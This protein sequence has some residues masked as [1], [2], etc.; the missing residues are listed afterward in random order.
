M[1][2]RLAILIGNGRF[3]A[4]PSL[5]ELF[6][7]RHDVASLGRLLS[8]P[9]IGNYIVF[10]LIDRDSEQLLAEL[11]PLFSMGHAG[12]NV[13]LYYAGIV[14]SEPGR[15]LYLATTDTEMA[16]VNETALPVSSL[17]GLL[18]SC[19]AVETTVVFDCCYA[20]P[21]GSVDEAAI[22]H[23]LRRVRTDVSPDL[24][25]IASP[26]KTRSAVEREVPTDTGIEGTMTRCIVEGLS[27]G[28]ADRDGDNTTK[29]SELNE[30]LG[31]RMGGDRPLWAGPLEG[32]DPE[33]VANPN[34]IEGVDGEEYQWMVE[35]R[36]GVRRLVRG[37][38][39]VAAVI[40][41]FSAG[42]FL[43]RDSE[44]RRAV[45]VDEYYV[46]SGMPEVYGLVDSLDGIRATIDRT[47]WV[48]HPEPLDGRGPRYPSAYSFRLDP[49]NTTRLGTVNLRLRQWAQFEF[50]EG[51]Y[52]VGVAC[53]AG[54]NIAEVVVQLVDGQQYV[55]DVR[56]EQVGEGFFGFVS[57]VPINRLRITSTSTRFVAQHL[58]VY[59]E[60]E[61]ERAIDEAP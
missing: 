51:I 47:G 26:A 60:A 42:F 53:A 8:D 12:S 20:S 11:E 34:P 56:T 30:Y 9:E 1:S 17:K 2:D 38:V 48:E 52:A 57:Q 25:L 24:H 58:Y 50:T 33:I 31:M 41:L 15:G 21:A 40:A 10:E 46:G 18:R 4:D 49:G 29:S 22:E 3:D 54:L 6:G 35:A 36:R 32:V 7:P 27:T 28:A 14:L 44:A 55:F 43:T 23:D 45:R 61:H 59:A 16:R 5:P 37:L 13:L 39:A 19:G